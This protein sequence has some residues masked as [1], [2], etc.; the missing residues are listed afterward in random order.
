MPTETAKTRHDQ[1]FDG[2]LDEVKKAG[3]VPPSRVSEVMLEL[4]QANSRLLSQKT[5]LEIACSKMR[6]ELMKVADP[7]TGKSMTGTKADSVVAS[8]S[9]GQAL[10]VAKEGLAAIERHHFS[11]KAHQESMQAEWVRQR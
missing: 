11:L 2:F 4:S 9:E 1:I 10:A 7:E 8:S 3:L 6:E 5:L